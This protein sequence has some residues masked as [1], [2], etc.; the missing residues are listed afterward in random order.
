IRTRVAEIPELVLRVR[1]LS[2]PGGPLNWGYPI[3]LAVHGPEADRVRELAVKL[4]ERLRQGKKLTDVWANPE[5][6]PRPQLYLD[7]DRAAVERR[8]VSM[9]DVFSTL[10]TYLGSVEVNDFNRFGRTWR[11]RVQADNQLRE[12]AE[13]LRQLKVRNTRGEM[14]PL[15]GLATVREIEA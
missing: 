13:G 4:A 5:S 1:D 14:V 12:R 2:A 7:V 8:G 3:D 9:K 6:A 10:Q 11:I 15:S